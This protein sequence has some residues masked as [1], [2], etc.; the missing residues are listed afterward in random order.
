MK[1]FIKTT[2]AVVLG[3]IICSMLS[4]MFFAALIP[5]QS[6]KPVVPKGA[7]LTI[8]GLTIDEQSRSLPGILEIGNTISFKENTVIGIWD[9]IHSINRAAQDPNIK[10]IYLKPETITCGTAHLQELRTAL[11]NFRE[12]GKPVIAY[13]DAATTGSYY[14]AS[15]ADKVYMSPYTGATYMLTGI[16]GTL[17]FIK[18]LLDRMG[19]DIQLIR[20]GKYKA[21]GEMFIR[22]NASPENIEQ[23]KEMITSIWK[24]MSSQIAASRSISEAD[25]NDAIDNLKLA[26]PQD[27]VDHKLCDGLVGRIELEEKLCDLAMADKFKDIKSIGLADYNAAAVPALKG[28]KKMAIIYTQGDIVDGNGKEGVAGDRFA[29]IIAKVRADSSIT[30]VVLRVNSPGG[31]VMASEKIKA[32]L[33]AL[34]ASKHLVASYG[35]YAASGGYWISNNAERVFSNP[36]TI[37]G[38]IGVFGIVPDFAGTLKNVA[39]VT[40]TSVNSHQHSDMYSLVRP[41]DKQEYAYIQKGIEDVYERFLDNVSQGRSMAREDVDEIGQGRVWTGA[42]AYEIGLVDEL[43]T[44]EDA[45]KYAASLG[46]EEDLSKWNIVSYP[47][48]ASPMEEIMESFGKTTKDEFSVKFRSLAGKIEKPRILARLPYEVVIR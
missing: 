23:N 33:D 27:F 32:E 48:S 6:A 39:H 47:K 20:H 21:A 1:Q 7:V 15:V 4:V 29:K 16:S 24:S 28:A 43:G 37:T 14:L 42:N 22:N 3:I 30:A 5:S 46:G 12:S 45:I 40:V 13:M 11:S 36:A 41:L 9:A 35:D 31:S 2:L 18:D 38:S 17:F 19:V 26:L 8:G 34:A 10:F 25:L 44:I